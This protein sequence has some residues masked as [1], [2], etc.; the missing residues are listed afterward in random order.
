MKKKQPPKKHH[1][2]VMINGK[3]YYE[4]YS[5]EAK[6]K[7]E[8][9]KVNQIVH[10][11]PVGE[12]DWRSVRQIGLY[13]Q[14]CKFVSERVDLGNCSTY[15]KTDLFTR[16]ECDLFDRENSIM[17]FQGNL[18]YSPLHSIAFHNMG[19]LKACGYF[20][21]A[22]GFMAGITPGYGFDIDKFIND[23]KNSC[24]GRR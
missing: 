8:E 12:T 16:A 9:Y 17:D 1:Q 24:I 20:Q 2:V 6:K 19:H 13:F 4:P 15:V 22:Y 14:A 5:E 18:L 10:F 11:N 23:V 21:E 7:I 3:K